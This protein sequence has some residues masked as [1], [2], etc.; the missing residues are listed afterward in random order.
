[1]PLKIRLVFTLVASAIVLTLVDVV[2]HVIHIAHTKGPVALVVAL[3]LLALCLAVVGMTLAAPE[4]G[5]NRPRRFV[6]S[7][8]AADSQ[9][10][11]RRPTRN[12][13]R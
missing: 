5:L 2:A 10:G 12:T 7:V 11:T 6:D 4:A 3:A 9:Q 1:M 8:R 13:R